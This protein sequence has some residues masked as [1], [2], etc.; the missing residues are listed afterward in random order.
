MNTFR[1]LLSAGLSLGL[2]GSLS[3]CPETTSPGD[4][5]RDASASGADAFVDPTLDAD[6]VAMPDAF[7]ALDAPGVDAPG[8]DAPG[9]DAP[10]LDAA[11]S[12]APEVSP[13]AALSMLDGGMCMDLPPDPTR[14]AE[15]V[16]SPC[17]PP[18]SSGGGRGECASDADC[19]AG[20]NGRCGFGRGG[21]FCSYDECFRD[22]DCEADE[23]CLC[24][25]SGGGN[26]CVG[27]GC[28]TNNDCEPG[29]A[30][31]P[32]FGSCGHYFGYI[33]FQCHTPSDECTV[34]A[35]CGGTAYCAFDPAISHWVCSTA[36]CVG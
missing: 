35:D 1:I 26:A 19:M 8:V 7:S 2:A 25:S 16:C 12:D 29:L 34:D 27:T 10:G 15:V 22:S 13:D 9:A 3:G 14:P 28:R 17:R 24:D 23:A 6:V 5:G 36:E 11:A 20:M 21:T 4:A 31:S 18:G 30:C 32:T 33:G